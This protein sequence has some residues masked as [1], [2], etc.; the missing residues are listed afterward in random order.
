[1]TGFLVDTNVVS[2]TQRP[3]PATRVVAWLD[4]AGAD[5]LFIS[6]VSLGELAIGVSGLPRGE[7]RSALE[8]WLSRVVAVKYQGRI[9]PFDADAAWLVGDPMARAK[10]SGRPAQLPDAQIAATAVRHNLTV[11]TRDVGDFA[12]FG[13]PLVN[14]WDIP[15]TM[16]GNT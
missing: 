11:V 7:R 9:L 12:A 15:G 14:P 1:V 2:E 4:G 8:R 5:N 6:A 13:L 3:R 10:A 16:E